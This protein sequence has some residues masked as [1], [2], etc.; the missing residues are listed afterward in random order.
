MQKLQ[1]FL[2]FRIEAHFLLLG[3]VFHKCFF[4][5]CERIK[6]RPVLSVKNTPFTFFAF[7]SPCMSTFFKKNHLLIFGEFRKLHAKIYTLSVKIDREINFQ[8]WLLFIAFF[9]HVTNF[10]IV[11]WFPLD[12]Y[13]KLRSPCHIRM[14]K[15]NINIFHNKYVLIKSCKNITMTISS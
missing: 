1:K 4:S 5:F 14:Y 11:Q 7:F 13:L 15:T 3:G 12:W 6:L 9:T 8:S 10:A 2:F